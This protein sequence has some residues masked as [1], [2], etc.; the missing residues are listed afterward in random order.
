MSRRLTSRGRAMRI[1][2]RRSLLPTWRR[3]P[4]LL[5]GAALG[6]WLATAGTALPA[7]GDLDASFGAGGR[8]VVNLGA[9]ETAG[10]RPRSR[11]PHRRGRGEAEPSREPRRDRRHRRAPDAPG[12][13]RHDLRGPL[14]LVPPR[15]QPRRRRPGRRRAAG[16]T[17]PG[18][19]LHQPGQRVR[20][21]PRESGRHVRPDLRRRDGTFSELDTAAGLGYSSVALQPDG[22]ILAVGTVPSAPPAAETDIAAVRLTSAGA[23]DGSYGAGLR[24]VAHQLPAGPGAPVDR[25]RERDRPRAGREDHRRRRDERPLRE[26]LRG[27]APAQPPGDARPLVRPGN[28][29][30]SVPTGADFFASP[31]SRSSPTGRSSSPAPAW[32]AA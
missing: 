4:F 12:R 22:R 21:P 13:H 5:L 14:R 24:V 30:A 29:T 1:L 15:L 10:R 31:R 27:R 17:D 25:F 23:F 20:R 8:A 32:S 9:D 2:T 26:Q 28:G 18:R 11:R 6:L 16:R 3:P 19:R 7:A